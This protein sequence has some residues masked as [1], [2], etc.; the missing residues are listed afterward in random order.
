MNK[1]QRIHLNVDNIDVDK[2]VKIRLEQ[3]VDTLEF[4]SMSI[5]TKDIY[6]DF[7]ADYG[8]LVGRV[9]AN[10]GI[11]VPNAKISIFV[12]VT[13]EDTL[14]GSV[15][16]IYPY[17]SPRDKNNEGKRYNL[18]P[19][20]SKR[21]PNTR[22]VTP[23]QPF[24]SFPIKE[25]FVVNEPFLDVYKKYYKY[26][27]LTNDSGDYMIFGVPI[28]VQT[29]HMSVD[30]TDIGEY[31]MTPAA[32]VSNLG[33]SPNLFTENNTK[34]KGSSDLN[35]LPHI[36]LQDIAV[37]I[38]PF[39][40]DV[41]NFEI[42]ITRQDFRIRSTL[43]N[44][45]T[46][47]G[48]V[49]TDPDKNMWGNQDS[50]K[51]Q[52]FRLYQ[53]TGK[54]GYRD[55]ENIGVIRKRIGPPTINVYYYPSTITDD[56]ITLGTRINDMLLLDKSEY[57]TYT[58]N[59]SFVVIINCNRRK[60]I[61]NEQGGEEVVEDSY[62]GGVYTEFRGF[63]TLE[64]SDN[65]MPMN[66]QYHDDDKQGIY[67]KPLRQRL[68]F[69]QHANK[70]ETFKNPS[71]SDA[72]PLN[73]AWRKEHFTFCGGGIYTL[74]KFHGIVANS[75]CENENGQTYGFIS[76][77]RINDACHGS[78]N[79]N[80]GI[81]QTN[82]YG[83]SG[84]SLYQMCSNSCIVCDGG[85]AGDGTIKLFG[86]NWLNMS[87]YLPQ[88]GWVSDNYSY[89]YCW[90]SNSQFTYAKKND[91]FYMQTNN[92][93]IAGLYTD[94]MG[95]ARSDLNWT[96]IVCVPK[97]DVLKMND[98]P[99][100]GF[101]KINLTGEEALEGTSYRNGSYVPPGWSC[102]APFNGGRIM[103]SCECSTVDTNTYFFKGIDTTDCVA[104]LVCLGVV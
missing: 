34:I 77:D 95:F 86:A 45:F 76:N 21:D 36:E 39:W 49:F 28:G 62:Q 56:E 42:G 69:P 82:D 75:H 33:Y 101:L 46:I 72:E 100:K 11:G 55:W 37:D 27:A 65:D 70:G 4:L 66:W 89:V 15:M 103:G 84:N 53:M 98:W 64:I 90:R 51:R 9:N 5:D 79:Q 38:A 17:K 50:G 96:D 92:Q 22:I 24:G 58:Q 87:I 29:V 2:Y 78:T 19:R 20:V 35:D 23:K 73:D 26:T 52:V 71:I 102:A 30:I 47:F 13:D 83:Y 99:T 85:W 48:S 16:S 67:V 40:G 88:T 104:Y 31:S 91:T 14:D 57:S 8:V 32:M 3:D 93:Q 7:N 59:G 10:N 43:T 81:I 54:D 44:T 12:P 94:T 68:K 41:E 18:L 1:S 25:E 6:R 60:I 74:S 63:V 97:T 61:I 80:A